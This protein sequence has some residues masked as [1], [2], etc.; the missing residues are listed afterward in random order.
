MTIIREV[1][2]A[3]SG[4]LRDADCFKNV[5]AGQFPRISYHL[6]GATDN[7]MLEAA[8]SKID[9]HFSCDA[10]WRSAFST[11]PAMKNLFGLWGK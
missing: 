6:G 2:Y 3:A 11:V 7:E 8:A 10:G 9:S 4:V 5:R 1:F